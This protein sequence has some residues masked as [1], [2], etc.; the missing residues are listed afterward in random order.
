MFAVLD[1][2][3][4]NARSIIEDLK[5]GTVPDDGAEYFTAGRDRWL[6]SLRI[7]L[8]DIAEGDRKIRIFNGRYGDGKTH[9][10]RLLRSIALESHFVVG[11]VAISKEVPL[12]Q[13]SLLYQAIVRSLHTA[14]R[15]TS[16]GL[17]VIIDPSSPDP[18][19][20]AQLLSLAET[21]RGL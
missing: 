17:G 2:K 12:S 19:I 7:N 13:W 14:A 3:P 11:Y 15:P 20:G 9:L 10:M 1:I 21:V 4:A 8:E 16:P 18:A 6:Q 5:T